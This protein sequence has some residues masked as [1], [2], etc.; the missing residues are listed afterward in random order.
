[1]R[2]GRPDVA[3]SGTELKARLRSTMARRRRWPSPSPPPPPPPQE[4]GARVSGERGRGLRRGTGSCR[5]RPSLHLGGHASAAGRSLPAAS[6]RA[7]S[8][9]S[10][11]AAAN[12]R[13]K[14]RRR[15]GSA[16]AYAVAASSGWVNRR[17]PRSL[18]ISPASTARCTAEAARMPEGL[19]DSLDRRTCCHGHDQD[20]RGSARPGPKA[21]GP[22]IRAGCLARAAGQRSRQHEGAVAQ[23]GSAR[24]RT[25]GCLLRSRCTSDPHQRPGAEQRQA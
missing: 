13:C 18:S 6:W 7:R 22:P 16:S 2:R 3:G 17:C 20:R 14:R 11:T 21:D 23:H 4:A 9:T 10:L 15:T 25:A 19:I 12:L 1:M 24:A 5:S 8:S